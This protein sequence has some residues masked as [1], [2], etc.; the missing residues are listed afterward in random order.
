M[1]TTPD[2]KVGDEVRVFDGWHARQDRTSA[3]GKVVK[4][5][6][7]LVRIKYKGRED[8]F[9]IDTGIINESGGG[10]EF[11]TLA[12]VERDE[13]RTIAMF[14][15]NAHRIEIKTGYDRSFTLEQIEAL[16]ALVA[17]FDQTEG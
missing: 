1:T 4:V 15:L 13:R 10:A 11:M 12:Q 5:G 9:R 7:T 17:T 14:V 2:I 6:R 8:A 16:A 3:P